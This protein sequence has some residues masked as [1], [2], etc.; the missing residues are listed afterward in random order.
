MN[1]SN[2]VHAE[3][4]DGAAEAAVRGDPNPPWP[5]RPYAWYVATVLTAAYTLS[6]IDRQVLG[7]LLEPI[8]RQLNLTDTQVSLL[9]G[10]AFAL[11]YVTLGLPL[12]RLADRTNRR[13]LILAGVF[14]GSSHLAP[15]AGFPPTRAPVR[16]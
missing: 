15:R 9:A 6:Y 8:R 5:R 11:F 10:S 14:D 12:G 3:F 2:V 4:R 13:N 16:S 1:T 7:L